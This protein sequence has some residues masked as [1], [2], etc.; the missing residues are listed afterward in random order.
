MK[1]KINIGDKLICIENK[2]NDIFIHFT[3]GKQY[4]I[5]FIS[6]DAI[7]VKNDYLYNNIFLISEYSCAANLWNFFSNDLKEV[8]KLK[9]KKL[10]EICQKSS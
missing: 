5:T 7:Q 2:I 9:L 1:S 6:N 8:R 3:I 10:N 4:E